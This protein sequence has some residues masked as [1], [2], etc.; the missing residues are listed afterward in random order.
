MPLQ[1]LATLW[2]LTAAASI[3]NND[4]CFKEDAEYGK[5]VKRIWEG[6][7][8]CK[9]RERINTRV[10]RHPGLELPSVQRV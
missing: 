2:E 5:I 10:I 8:T 6:D 1:L 7:I 4:H 9:D 3:L